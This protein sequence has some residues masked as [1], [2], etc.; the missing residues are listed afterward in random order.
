MEELDTW[1]IRFA[2][3]LY[4]KIYVIEFN[5]FV[6]AFWAVYKHGEHWHEIPILWDT[7]EH[8]KFNELIRAYYRKE[9][10]A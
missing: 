2:K 4:N 7:I 10:V 1:L 9:V 5:A 6:S 3:T 8:K